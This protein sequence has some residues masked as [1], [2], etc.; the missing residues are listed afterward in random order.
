MQGVGKSVVHKTARVRASPRGRI[1]SPATHSQMP[2]ALGTST[3]PFEMHP[4]LLRGHARRRAD[5]EAVVVQALEQQSRALRPPTPSQLH[6][7]R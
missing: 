5:G 2:Q 3:P 6:T 4:V 1:H 7:S